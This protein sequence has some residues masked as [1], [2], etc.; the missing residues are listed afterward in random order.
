MNC[1]NVSRNSSV[2]TSKHRFCR[3]LSPGVVGRRV[4]ADVTDVG[5]DMVDQ[6][7]GSLVII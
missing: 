3:K 7:L 4:L 6:V 2:A 1:D 5:A